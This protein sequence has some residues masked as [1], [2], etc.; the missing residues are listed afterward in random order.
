[1]HLSPVPED[2]SRTGNRLL[3][4]LT[5]EDFKR[6]H[7]HL[8]PVS[9]PAKQPLS[10]AG[11]PIEH[12]YFPQGGMVS[13]VTPL[14]DGAVIEVGLI[15]KE[16]LVGAPI[17]LGADIAPSETMVQ[18]PGAALKIAASLLREQVGRSPTLLALLLRYV[19]ALHVQVSQS[20]ACNGRHPLNERLARWLLMAHDRMDDDVLPLSHEYIAM[21]IGVRRSGVTVAVGM[22]KTAG[23]IRNSHGKIIILDRRGLEAVSCECYRIVRD[24]YARLIP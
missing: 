24:E 13:M 2:R 9:W 4:A 10:A 22:L 19:Q 11:Q 6:L 5:G 16:G 14:A 20:A 8:D 12:V 7:P 18:M 3:D 21:M 17:L 15:G 1:M 23:L